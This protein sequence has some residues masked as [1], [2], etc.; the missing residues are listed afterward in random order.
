[1]S[2]LDLPQER[3]EYVRRRHGR[4]LAMLTYPPVRSA[5]QQAV[6]STGRRRQ[7]CGLPSGMVQGGTEWTL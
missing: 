4:P 6:T 7:N 2:D 3:G 5:C 1:M